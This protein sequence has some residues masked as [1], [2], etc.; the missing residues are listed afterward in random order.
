MPSGLLKST[1]TP[2]CRCS[3]TLSQEVNNN[4]VCPSRDDFH[5]VVLKYVSNITAIPFQNPPM[6]FLVQSLLLL[7]FRPL[8]HVYVYGPVS[9]MLPAEAV[10]PEPIPYAKL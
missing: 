2:S 1:S 8:N 5:T 4:R 7:I 10:Q 3:S 6:T 9:L